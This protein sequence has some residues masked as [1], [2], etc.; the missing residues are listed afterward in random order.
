MSSSTTVAAFLKRAS[1]QLMD[2][3]AQFTRWKQP[4]L[5][6]WT[7]DG[8]I[9]IAKFMPHACARVDVVKLKTGTRQSIEAIAAAE[10]LPGDGSAASGVLHGNFL[11]FVSHNMGS[12]GLT[13]GRALRIVDRDVLD[14]TNPNWHLPGKSSDAPTQYVFDPR[15]PKQF[16]VC[17]GIASSATVWVELAGLFDPKKLDSTLDYTAGAPLTT[18]LSVDDKF[19]D[20]LLNYV[21]ARAYM[22]DAEAQGNLNLVAAHSKLFVDSINAQAHAM[23]GVN[24]NLKSLPMTGTAPATSS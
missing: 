17:P 13:P 9:A 24:P 11:Q 3:A 19:V 22:K 6:E 4:E 1:T 14:A 18:T 21:L 15:T 23:T 16:W 8:Q 20:D 7:N 5:L 2:L 10:I 12:D